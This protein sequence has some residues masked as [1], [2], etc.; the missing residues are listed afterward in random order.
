MAAQPTDS[1]LTLHPG[2]VLLLT[3]MPFGYGAYRGFQ[4]PALDQVVGKVLARHQLPV[5][6]NLQEAEEP[7]RKA[8]GS[9]V[10]GRALR[11]ATLASTASFCLASSFLFY[12]NGWSSV[13]QAMAE[14]REWAQGRRKAWDSYFGIENRID[15]DHPEVQAVAGMTEEEELQHIS[16]RYLPD[17]DWESTEDTSSSQK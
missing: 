17:E 12:A 9:A 13:D 5:V 15:R 3:S 1:P 6:A 14:T 2:H 7:I 16:N 11:V 4:Q 10:A 8:I